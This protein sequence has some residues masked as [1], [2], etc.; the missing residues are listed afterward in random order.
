MERWF[1]FAGI[2]LCLFS[3]WALL[4]RDWVRLGRISREAMGEVVEYRLARDDGVPTYAP[5]YRFAAEGA[6]HR[7]TDQVYS[8]RQHPPL[9]TQVLLRYP[10][11]R[12][13]LARPPRL[14]LWLGVYA[15]L[16]GLL[17]MLVAKALDWLPH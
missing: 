12:P 11:G 1:L 9:G 5:V 3:L 8:R 16:I 4:H 6:E 17:A 13:D 7:V 15:L 14:L 10:L 2:G